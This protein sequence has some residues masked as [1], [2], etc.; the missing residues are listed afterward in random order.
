MTRVISMEL[1]FDIF[2]FIFFFF[3]SSYLTLKEKIKLFF[4]KKNKTHLLSD[5]LFVYFLFYFNNLDFT[6]ISIQRE[7]PS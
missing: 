5:F 7:I 6:R 2:L 3:L 4:N 1:T